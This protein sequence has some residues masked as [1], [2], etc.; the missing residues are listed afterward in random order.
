MPFT[1]SALLAVT[2]L[3]LSLGAFPLLS[4][5]EDEQTVEAKNKQVVLD[6]YDL[7]FNRHKPTEAAAKYIGDQYVQHNPDVPNGTEA[8]TGYFEGFFKENPQSHVV[9]AHVLADGDLVALHLNSKL[10]KADKGRA[11]V[12][13]FRLKNGKIIEHWDVDQPVPATTANGNTMFDNRAK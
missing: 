13:I 2:V 10:N 3:A 11:I 1:K 12:D 9:I 5:A 8:F 7:A 6:F 4:H